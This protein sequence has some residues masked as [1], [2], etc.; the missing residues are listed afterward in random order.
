LEAVQ[1]YITPDHGGNEQNQLSV[2]ARKQVSGAHGFAFSGSSDLRR[3][4][5]QS[6][7]FP[8]KYFGTKTNRRI[9][10]GLTEAPVRLSGVT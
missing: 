3:L 5:Q 4:A 6:C 7:I 1:A 9:D 8:A 2:K 10:L